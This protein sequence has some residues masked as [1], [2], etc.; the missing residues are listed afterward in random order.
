MPLLPN[1]QL[2]AEQSLENT[3]ALCSLFS[4]VL[5][6]AVPNLFWLRKFLYIYFHV[7]FFFI[8]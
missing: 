3:S 1:T 4:V 6:V 7:E 8:H 2:I 5:E